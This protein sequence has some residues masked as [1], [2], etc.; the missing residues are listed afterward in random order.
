MERG[1]KKKINWTHPVTSYQA[2]GK[3]NKQLIHLKTRGVFD[4]T[5]GLVKS[6][7][8]GGHR[9]VGTGTLPSLFMTF[10]PGRS[11]LFARVSINSI[12]HFPAGSGPQGLCSLCAGSLSFPSYLQTRRFWWLMVLLH[13]PSLFLAI[14]LYFSTSLLPKNVTFEGFESLLNLTLN[15]HIIVS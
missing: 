4:V 14:H 2:I 9:G 11:C 5:A 7:R 13:V 15:Y 3:K 8:P 1:K 10:G 12:R 6:V